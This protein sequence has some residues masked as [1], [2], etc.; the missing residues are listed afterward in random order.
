LEEENNMKKLLSRALALVMALSL[1]ACGG[2]NNDTNDNAQQEQQSPAPGESAPAD[3]NENTAQTPSGD[4]G[5]LAFPEDFAEGVLY[6]TVTRGTTFEEL[7][8]SREAIEAVQNGQPIPSGTVITLLI[9]REGELS[10]YFVMEK[11]PGG[12]AQYPPDLRNGEWEY[13]AFTADASVDYEEDIG[14][15]LSCHGN[16]ERDDYVNTLDEMRNYDLDTLIGSIG[17]SIGLP[18]EDWD[19][20][21]ITDNQ[22]NTRDHIGFHDEEKAGL[23][24]NVLLTL[25]LH[26]YME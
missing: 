23:I 9:Y 13:Q 7:Y 2:N 3:T 19:V 5:E 24:K 18:I 20:K 8:T 16:R 25:Y 10:Q 11:R 14:R 1:A 17:G 4:G 6:T 22:D 12:G 26:Q 21:M 15:C